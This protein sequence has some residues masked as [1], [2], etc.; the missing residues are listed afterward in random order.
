MRK[1]KN[2]LAVGVVAS[3][4]LASATTDIDGKNANNIKCAYLTNP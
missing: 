2:I 3:S 4:S 1:L